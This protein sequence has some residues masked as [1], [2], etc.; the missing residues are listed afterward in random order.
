MIRHH[1]FPYQ[2]S[3]FPKS[4]PRLGRVATFRLL[5][6]IP[7]VLVGGIEFKFKREEGEE[8]SSLSLH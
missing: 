7:V 8:P 5:V 3:L 1:G 6:L 2:A 4:M